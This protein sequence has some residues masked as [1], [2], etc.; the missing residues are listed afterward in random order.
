MAHGTPDW[1]LV[2]PKQTT[3]GLDDIGEAMVRLGSPHLWDRRGDVLW[4]T[5]FRNGLGDMIIA[6]PP[7]TGTVSL[8]TGLARQGAF[9]VR[10]ASNVSSR[11]GLEK[12]FPLPVYSRI[13]L[14]FS[15]SVTIR[16]DFIIAEIQVDNLTNTLFGY[17]R[18][19]QGNDE[20][21]YM[22][23]PVGPTWVPFATNLNP[24]RDETCPNTLKLVIDLT[25]TPPEFV[26]VIFNDV[27]YNNIAGVPL[28]TAATGNRAYVWIR[29]AHVADVGG[30]AIVYFDN[31][32]VTQNEP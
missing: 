17:V 8:S 18:Y 6:G 20:L 13:G 22:Q 25:I 9:C 28:Y 26:R 31:V 16:S 11:V 32:I 30:A 4:L 5:D 15:F 1:G 14:E 23:E 7:V 10:M 21:Q 2:G 27:T 24:I 29:I 19:D 3:Y 12:G